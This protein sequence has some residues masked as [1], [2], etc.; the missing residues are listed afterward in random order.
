MGELI[1]ESFTARWT[2]PVPVGVNDQLNTAMGVPGDALSYMR[3]QFRSEHGPKFRRAHNLC[4]H[5]LLGQV[6]LEIAR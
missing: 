2:N 4:R 5:A 3:G 6:H 1:V